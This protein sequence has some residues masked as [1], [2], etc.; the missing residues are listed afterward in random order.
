VEGG[1]GGG[2]VVERE[3]VRVVVGDDVIVCCVWNG[4]SGN[5]FSSSFPILLAL[6]WV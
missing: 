2:V 6:V 5:I 1:G 4:I 3:E